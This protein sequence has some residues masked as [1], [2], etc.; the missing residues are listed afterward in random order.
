MLTSSWD[1]AIENGDFVHID[2]VQSVVQRVTIKLKLWRGEWFLDTDQGTPWI[3]DILIKQVSESGSAAA[4]RASILE[5]EDVQAI[6]KFEFSINNETRD[7]A[8]TFNAKI[9]DAI[10]EINI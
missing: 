3:Q 8:L 10:Q 4:L 5:V 1:L 7:F 2:E 9:D 6:D